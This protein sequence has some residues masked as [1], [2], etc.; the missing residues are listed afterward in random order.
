MGFVLLRG[1]KGKVSIQKDSSHGLLV[2]VRL[3]GV[4]SL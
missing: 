2:R 4:E 1:R 3:E